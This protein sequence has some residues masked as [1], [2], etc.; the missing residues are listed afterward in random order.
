MRRQGTF[1]AGLNYLTPKT[2]LTRSTSTPVRPFD[3]LAL[4]DWASGPMV[5]RTTK[6]GFEVLGVACIGINHAKSWK[7]QSKA[8]FD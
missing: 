1:M 3:V 4:V 6:T 2:G 8:G 5:L 7:G